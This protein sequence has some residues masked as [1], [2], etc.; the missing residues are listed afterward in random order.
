MATFSRPS[1][2]ATALTGQTV[3]IAA[4][5]RRGFELCNLGAE[6]LFVAFGLDA[7]GVGAVASQGIVIEAGASKF[8]GDAVYGPDAYP[9]SNNAVSQ[10]VYLVTAGGSVAWCAHTF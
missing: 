3:A 1:G 10:D 8:Y 9:M 6:R 7:L 2:T 5:A 4:G